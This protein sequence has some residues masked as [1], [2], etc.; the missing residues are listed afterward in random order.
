MAPQSTPWLGP[1]Y[2]LRTS[3]MKGS[4]GLRGEGP[5]HLTSFI[6]LISPSFLHKGPWPLARVTMHSGKEVTRHARVYGTLGLNGCQFQDA[7]N[8]SVGHQSSPSRSFRGR[9]SVSPDLSQWA[10]G[11]LEPILQLLPQFWNASLQ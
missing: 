4:P 5:Q 2:R 7:Q 8:I 9:C 11:V 10:Q 1:V 3:L 6:L